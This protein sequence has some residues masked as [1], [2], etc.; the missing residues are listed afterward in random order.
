LGFDRVIINEFKIIGCDV[1]EIG[2]I[3]NIKNELRILG[4]RG[5]LY[6][7]E[8]FSDVGVSSICKKQYQSY[9]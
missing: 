8:T 9:C 3:R 6:Q 5:A 7:S 4:R 2:I 1:I